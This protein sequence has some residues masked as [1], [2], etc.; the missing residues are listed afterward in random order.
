MFQST[1]VHL[2]LAVS[3]Q[4]VIFGPQLT[5]DKTNL[6]LSFSWTPAISDCPTAD[7]YY[8][9]LSANCGTCPF[10]TSDTSITCHNV[11]SCGLCALAVQTV[12]VVNDYTVK[13]LLSDPVYVSLNW[14]RNCIQIISNNSET[15]MGET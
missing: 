3:S 8:Y 7:V 4:P 9:I 5:A 12:A 1:S 14:T 10:A 2:F 11:P 15:N 6:Q 13:D